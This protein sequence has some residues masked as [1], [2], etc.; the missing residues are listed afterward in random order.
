[1]EIDSEL[2]EKSSHFIKKNWALLKSAN[3]SLFE[4]LKQKNRLVKL[5]NLDFHR[6]QGFLIFAAAHTAVEHEFVDKNPLMK[7]H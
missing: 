3:E 2:R 7:V 5:I 4:K 1:M 6:I